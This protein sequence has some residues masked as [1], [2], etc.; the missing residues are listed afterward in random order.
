MWGLF[1]LIYSISLQ[2]CSYFYGGIEGAMA[3]CSLSWGW[4][5]TKIVNKWLQKKKKKNRSVNNLRHFLWETRG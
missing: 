4:L 3:D 2:L 1:T 5:K